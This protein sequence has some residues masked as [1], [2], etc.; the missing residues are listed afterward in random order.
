MLYIVPDY[1]EEFACMAD[2]CE[3]TCCA[4]WKIMRI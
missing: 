1:Y 4:G 3:D 2:R